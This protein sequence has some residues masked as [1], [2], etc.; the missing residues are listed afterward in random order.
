[1]F[2]RHLAVVGAVDDHGVGKARALEGVE[3]RAHQAVEV[4]H[5]AVVGLAHP[6]GDGRVDV[7]YA[8]VGDPLVD[9]RVDGGLLNDD[10]SLFYPVYG[11]IL[12]MVG[13]QAIPLDQVSLKEISGNE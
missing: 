7:G 10:C 1:M 4:G 3:Q 2:A 9:Q 13:D 5:H 6:L 12:T 11:G 8:A